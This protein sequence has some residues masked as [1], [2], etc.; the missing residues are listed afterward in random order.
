LKVFAGGISCVIRI[1]LGVGGI[2]LA[3]LGAS[4]DIATGAVGIGLGVLGYVLGTRR[5][6]TATVI[7]GVPVIFFKTAVNAGLIPSVALVGYSSGG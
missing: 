4:T 2:L 7:L 6:G 5:L 3:L 1:L